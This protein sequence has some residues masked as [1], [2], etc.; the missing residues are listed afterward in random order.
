MIR[1]DSPDQRSFEQILIGRERGRAYCFYCPLA[2]VSVSTS[3]AI[4]KRSCRS[5]TSCSALSPIRV[6]QTPRSVGAARMLPMEHCPTAKKIFA[7]APPSLNSVDVL[8]AHD[9]RIHRNG[10]WSLKPAANKERGCRCDTSRSHSGPITRRKAIALKSTKSED[11]LFRNAG[12]L[13]CRSE[14][15]R[16]LDVSKDRYL[17]ASKRVQPLYRLD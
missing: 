8:P 12:Q 10:C 3:M 17:S 13:S 9:Q 15:N 4:G 14:R 2:F 11:K 5:R 7:L 6:A 16:A 1:T